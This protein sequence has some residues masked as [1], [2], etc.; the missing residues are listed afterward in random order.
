MTNGT[1]TRGDFNSKRDILLG[2]GC[3]GYIR[4]KAL[5]AWDDLCCKQHIS[6]RTEGHLRDE[7]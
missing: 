3:V 2:L 6:T 5:P 7:E 1:A 4:G